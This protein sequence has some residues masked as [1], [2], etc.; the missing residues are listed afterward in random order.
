MNHRGDA[1]AGCCRPEEACGGGL[2]DLVRPRFYPGQV[3]TDRDLQDL[4]GWVRARLG[5]VR[6]RDGWGAVCGLAVAADPANP[7][8]VTVGPGYAVDAAGNDL[9]VRE[10]VAK[11]LP[12]PSDRGVRDCTA[13]SR[14]AGEGRTVTVG[15]FTIPVRDLAVFDVVACYAAEDDTPV[16][17]PGCRPQ[18]RCEYARTR[19]GV[20]VELVPVKLTADG[21]PDEPP[22]DPAADPGADLVAAFVRAFSVL[23]TFTPPAAAQPLPPVP[24]SAGRKPHEWLADY[25]RINPGLVGL[26]PG[27]ADWLKGEDAARAFGTPWG[28]AGV[29]FAVADAAR[30]AGAGCPEPGCGCPDAGVPVGRVWAERQGAGYAVRLASM[31]SPPRRPFAPD[32]G[33]EPRDVR[34]FV[35]RSFE[36]VKFDLGLARVTVEQQTFEVPADAAGLVAA[37]AAEAAIKDAGVAGRFEP[38]GTYSALETRPP[39]RHVAAFR[40]GKAADPLF[41]PDGPGGPLGVELYHPDASGP[42]G[43]EFADPP[44]AD[45]AVSAVAIPPGAMV[46]VAVRTD[47]RLTAEAKAVYL[48]DDLTKQVR[49]VPSPD[50]AKPI[51]AQ[52]KVPDQP[53]AGPITVTVIAADAATPPR[54]V[55]LSGPVPLPVTGSLPTGEHA[56]KLRFDGGVTVAGV[57]AAPGKEVVVFAGA[58][59]PVKATGPV[60]ASNPNTSEVKGKFQSA[61]KKSPVDADWAGGKDITVPVGAKAHDIDPAVDVE[62]TAPEYAVSFR[63]AGAKDQFDRGMPTLADPL[64]VSVLI[65]EEKG[66]T[67]GITNTHSPADGKTKSELVFT[68]ADPGGTGKACTVFAFTAQPLPTSAGLPGFASKAKVDIAAAAKSPPVE[69]RNDAAA[70]AE[71]RMTVEY[72]FDGADR[73]KAVGDFKAP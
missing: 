40:E 69:L 4:E 59:P 25:L 62:L 44:A 39:D 11:P 42:P 43:P 5:L 18:P 46:R 28:A 49:P 34:A 26:I 45:K 14:D 33:H 41:A 29:L 67:A 31:G 68:N 6:L 61:A 22:P 50:P 54:L 7:A 3:L 65:R 16:T 55:A 9:V 27:M 37:F 36:E 73:Q 10:A 23:A 56:P 53:P 66:L 21:Q 17:A 1:G 60:R 38:G 30:R 13:R 72:Q 70:V 51:V 24:P 32:R 47:S 2:P 19:E 64:T 71:W 52:V 12:R 15:P 58:T 48:Y 63:V 20:K 8:G 57:D 35:G